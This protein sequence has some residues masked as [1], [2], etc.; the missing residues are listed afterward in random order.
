MFIS[1]K[2]ILNKRTSDSMGAILITESNNDIFNDYGF[3]YS[4]TIE[5][6]KSY[7]DNPSFFKGEK[8]TSEI[9]LKI[10]LVDVNYVP[11]KWSDY[12]IEEICAWIKTD[13]FVEFI[14]EDN[15]ELIYYV[16][17]TKIAKKFTDNLEGY[18]EVTFQPFTN[19]A[20]KSD[21]KTITIKENIERKII[22]NNKSNVEENYMPIVELT[23]LGDESTVNIIK[24]ISIE[25][26][27]FEITG[28]EKNEKVI[29]DNL[30]CTVIDSKGKNRFE[31]CNRHWLR[32][33]K[34]EN[35]LKIEGNC[36]LTIK[37][38]YPILT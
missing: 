3:M 29:I 23:N 26:E 22:I 37:S 8:D 21:V 34:G 38:K 20:Y 2:F 18:L 32:L 16:K 5:K 19:F 33:K 36:K 15:V 4:E 11:K 13:D 17:A 27:Q 30:Y 6:V 14:S 12:D 25:N 24:N 7:N 31:K 9:V 1:E 28:I 10:C 35:E